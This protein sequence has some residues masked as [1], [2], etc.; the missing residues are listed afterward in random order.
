MMVDY[1][2]GTDGQVSINNV[3]A[4]PE[5]S[6]LQEQVKERMLATPLQLAPALDS[7]GK[8]R[9]VKRRYSFT[10]TKD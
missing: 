5:N 7:A 6:F 4:T 2:I 1:E 10:I 3:T 8:P 9:T